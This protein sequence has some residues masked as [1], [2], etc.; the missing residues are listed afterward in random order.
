MF[1]IFEQGKIGEIAGFF[2]YD[3][4]WAFICNKVNNFGFKFSS[5]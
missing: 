1:A 2:L 3:I 5:N 4:V